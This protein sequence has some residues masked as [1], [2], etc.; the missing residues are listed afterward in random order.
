MIAK[1]IKQPET[2]KLFKRFL[3]M[4]NTW[5][6]ISRAYTEEN[7]RVSLCGWYNKDT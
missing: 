5:G 1:V 7:L 3:L 6:Y 2:T 4:N